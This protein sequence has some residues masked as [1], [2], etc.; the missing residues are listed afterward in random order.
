MSIP[1]LL[2]IISGQRKGIAAS[3]IRAGLSCL[4]PIYRLGVWYRNRQFDSRSRKI[5][6]VSAKVIS[7]GNITTGGTGKTPMVVWVCQFLERQKLSAGI[8]S[9]GY[10]AEVDGASKNDEAMEL[11]NRLPAVPHVQNRDRVRAAQEC[12]HDNRVDVIVLD[13]GFQHRRLHR[14][15]DIVL[16]DAS[17]PFGYDRLL[18]RGL[19]REPIGALCRADCVVV[20]RCDRVSDTG[21]ELIRD[22]IE[23]AT[24]APIVLSQTKASALIQFSGERS[25]IESLRS[26]RWFAFSAIGNPEAFEG[27]LLDSGFEL[28]G[29]M[30]FRDHHWFTADDLEAIATEARAAG[31][32]RLVCTHK[33]LVKVAR[34]QIDE[35]FVHAL[36]IETDMVE[37]E[38]MF[39]QLIHAS[40]SRE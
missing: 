40:L 21:L 39:E 6:S 12:I 22:R 9:R 27:S 15:L 4:T 31:A 37:G 20:T 10:G 35:I 32:E 19:L 3:A 38:E 2:K 7:I 26:N 17:N 28:V 14:D 11:E 13:D 30:Q 36:L 16:I 18:P 23:S 24:D 25:S 1:S 34:D 8:V 5:E 29:A 33:D